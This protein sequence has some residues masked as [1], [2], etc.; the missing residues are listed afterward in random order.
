MISL[1]W[2]VFDTDRMADNGNT[3][4]TV[5]S[6]RPEL[7]GIGLNLL[8]NPES[9]L[10]FSRD[11]SIPIVYISSHKPSSREIHVC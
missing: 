1:R 3:Q 5:V 7:G 8:E 11:K 9:R 4:L 10:D 2:G 6:N